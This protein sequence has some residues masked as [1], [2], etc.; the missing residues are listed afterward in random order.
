MC[1]GCKKSKP[2]DSPADQTTD[3]I[4][5]YYKG[6]LVRAFKINEQSTLSSD[7]FLSQ[8]ELD[9]TQ[10]YAA[11][12]RFNVKNIA[13]GPFTQFPHSSNYQPPATCGIVEYAD[14]S[15]TGFDYMGATCATTSRFNFH[16]LSNS[17][18]VLKGYFTGYMYSSPKDSAA[19]DSGVYRITYQNK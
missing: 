10:K 15:T 18:N 8:F 1:F 16:V 7:W 4:S 12:I 2:A 14:S 5:F 6:K 9:N 19:I 11:Y 13:V 17:N 3:N